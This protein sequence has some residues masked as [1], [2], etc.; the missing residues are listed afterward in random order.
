MRKNVPDPMTFGKVPG[1]QFK[2]VLGVIRGLEEGHAADVIEMGVREKHMRV[3]FG[4]PFQAVAEIA[5]PR[6]GVENQKLVA[7]PHLE[8]GGVAAIAH[9]VWRRTS[10]ASADPPKAD[11]EVV[12]C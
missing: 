10:D 4:A 12:L 5:Q 6:A 2:R 9:R 3:E 1:P 11:K 8:R 7:A